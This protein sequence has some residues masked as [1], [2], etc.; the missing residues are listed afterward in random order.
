MATGEELFRSEDCSLW[1]GAL[2]AYSEVLR[3]KVSEKSKNS[4]SKANDLVE[5]DEW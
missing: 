1:E 2:D 4:K 5:L 3:K